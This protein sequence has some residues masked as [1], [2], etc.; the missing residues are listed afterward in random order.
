MPYLLKSEPDAYSI[1]DLERDGETVWD[2]VANPQAVKVLAGMKRGEMAVIYHTGNERRTAGL[3]K[4]VSVDASDAKNPVVR[5]KF[6]KRA[7]ASRTLAEI[8]A[9]SLFAQSPLVKQGRL[10]VVPLSE[11]QYAWLATA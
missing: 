5:L 2:G 1:E 9:Q 11:A 10:S 4:V 6:V 3:A 7:A 8:K